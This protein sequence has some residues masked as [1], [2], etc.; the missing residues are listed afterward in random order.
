[1]KI[2][3]RC[4]ADISAIGLG[5]L[6][7]C[8][9]LADQL[10]ERG[11]NCT[12]IYRE[13][14]QSVELYLAE[15]EIERRKLPREASDDDQIDAMADFDWIILDSYLLS[16][17]FYSTVHKLCKSL[18]ISDY[19]EE[20]KIEAT[21]LCNFHPG[22]DQASYILEKNT[23]QFFGPKYALLRSSFRRSEPFQA[24]PEIKRVFISFGGADSK[25]SGIRFAKLL[26][27]NFLGE[28]HL[29]APS[30][31]EQKDLDYIEGLFSRATFQLSLH[32]NVLDPSSLMGQADLA[33]ASASTTAYELCTLGIPMIL[34]QT[35]DNQKFV[36]EGFRERDAA[37]VLGSVEDIGDQHFIEAY[38]ALAKDQNRRRNLSLCA[39]TMIDGQGAK[40]LAEAIETLS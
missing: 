39:S 10:I 28:L 3:I 21:A 31:I 8:L 34:L 9:S 20:F 12:L 37:V 27:G 26:H 5:H 6:I 13:L 16:S 24:K 17:R 22:A 15:H 33:I 23:K 30:G 18:V 36:S 19:P 1:M 32:S 2:G 11:H 14:D 29:L 40:R 7:R 25:E 38:R 4:D 35:A